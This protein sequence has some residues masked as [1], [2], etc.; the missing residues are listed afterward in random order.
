[1]NPA[2]KR[3]SS[4]SFRHLSSIKDVVQELQ[5]AP[6]GGTGRRRVTGGWSRVQSSQQQEPVKGDSMNRMTWLVAHRFQMA[7][8][9]GVLFVARA[10]LLATQAAPHGGS[11]SGGGGC[12]QVMGMNLSSATAQPGDHVGVNTS[13]T[14][15][16]DR[17]KR[18][19]VTHSFAPACGGESTL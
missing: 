15:C 13:I 12:A 16:S 9:L 6:A 18:Y 5:S 7:V 19:T 8:A 2:V 11:S 1:M 17:R 4:R 14:S 10:T 3:M